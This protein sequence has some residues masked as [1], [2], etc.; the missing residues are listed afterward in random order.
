MEDLARILLFT[1]DGKGKTTAALGL[2]LRAS[3]HGLGTVVI[4]FVKSDA[5]T[6]EVAAIKRLPGVEIVL[7]GRGFIPPEGDPEF[8]L[9]REAAQ[10]GLDLAAEALISGKYQVV[11]LDEI[12]LAVSRKLISGEK[13]EEVI[14]SAVPDM[15]VVLTGRNAPENLVALADTVTEMRSVK[16]GFQAGRKAQKGVEH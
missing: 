9:H 6:G 5:S 7:A 16:H 4:Q 13:V 1:G 15:C 14:R 11:I 2:A 12:C 8:A 10:M 3:G